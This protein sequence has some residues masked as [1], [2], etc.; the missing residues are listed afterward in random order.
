MYTSNEVT[1]I[2]TVLFPIECNK[3][4]LPGFTDMDVKYSDSLEGYIY[5]RKMKPTKK[6]FEDALSPKSS[7]QISASNIVLITNEKDFYVTKLCV[8]TKYVKA[9]KL[10]GYDEDNNFVGKVNVKKI[11]SRYSLHIG[12]NQ[13]HYCAFNK[14]PSSHFLS[15]KI[16]HQPANFI[17][18]FK[19]EKDRVWTRLF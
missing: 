18:F 2:I 6:N 8:Q 5:K 11:I 9:I 17:I 14:I 15:N 3:E 10:K 1:A 7:L 16:L 4:C 19:T 13:R 12:S